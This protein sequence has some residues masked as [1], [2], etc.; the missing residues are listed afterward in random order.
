MENRDLGGPKC[1]KFSPAAGSSYLFYK[2]K[3]PAAGEKNCIWGYLNKDL[4]GEIGP[5]QAKKFGIWAL[6]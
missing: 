5:P 2:G 3:G 4:Q 6:Y 1:Q